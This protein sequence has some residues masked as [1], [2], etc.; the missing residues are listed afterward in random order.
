MVLRHSSVNTR[1]A[2]PV[3]IHLFVLEG[4]S[5]PGLVVGLLASISRGKVYMV[6]KSQTAELR[7]RF[8]DF[9]VNNDEYGGALL[10]VLNVYDR[11]LDLM[12]SWTFQ[13]NAAAKRERA[14]VRRAM[15]NCDLCG[16][17]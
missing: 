17:S 7:R 8:D 12:A 4:I 3:S 11:M 14:A 5:I 6:T 16:K 15:E 1:S 9:I 2:L 10:E 13:A